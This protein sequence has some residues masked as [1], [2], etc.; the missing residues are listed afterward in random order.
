MTPQQAI[1]MLDRQVQQH[2]QAVKLERLVANQPS[3][4]KDGLRGFVR[5]YK[6][7]EIGGGIVQ[8]DTLVVLSPTAIAGSAFEA[9][10]PRRLDRVFT[11]GRRRT[12]E[13]AEAVYMNDVLVR[14]NLQV[15]G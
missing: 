10:L 8:G 4:E 13:S 7:D 3:I 9:D 6:P 5:G 11:T 2:G 12:V 14:I 1:G 15:R